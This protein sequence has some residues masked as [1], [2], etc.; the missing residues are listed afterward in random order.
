MFFRCLV[1]FLVCFL[2]TSRL[3][4]LDGS[5]EK[6]NFQCFKNKNK[7]KDNF[8]ISPSGFKK[9]IKSVSKHENTNNVL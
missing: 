4:M 8:Q 7:N 2:N 5:T 3:L 6:T 9:K 1:L